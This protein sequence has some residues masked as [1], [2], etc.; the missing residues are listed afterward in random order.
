MATKMSQ[1]ELG[2]LDPETYA[3]GNPETFGLPLDAY[4]YLREEEP[5]CLHT[6]EDDLL[7]DEVYVVSRYADIEAVDRD[8]ETFSAEEVVNF[9]KF[10]PI[11]KAM[12]AP[13]M[14][15]TDGGRHRDQRRVLS[16]KFTPKAIRGLEER[17]R[18]YAIDVVEA[19]L[20]KEGPINFIDEIAHVMPM[21][22]LGDVLGVPE[23]DRPKFFHWVDQFAAPFD[24]RITPSFE[25]VGKAI[26]GLYEYAPE[27]NEL[28]LRE[29]GDDVMSEIARSGW[30]AEEVK[31]NVVLLASGAAEST[32]TSLGHGMHEFLR[33]PELMAWLR[34]QADDIPST[35]AQEMVRISTP[36]THLC[37][38]VK[39]ETE[40]NGVE[41]KPGDY[42]A[43]LFAAGNFDPDAFENPEEFDPQRSP[44]A[45]L[46]FGRGPHS[47][48]G[49]H[50]AALEIKILLEELLQRTSDIKQVGPI[51]YIK[52]AYSRGVYELP[53]QLT[54]A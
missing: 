2:V 34:T 21:Q 39:K 17:F 3:N 9:W 53:V 19:A 11:G 20:A 6:F 24:T 15:T 27:L 44:N 12:G 43:M 35:V 50:V 1:S 29:P 51:S 49:K 38:Y 48:L 33:N 36:F 32:R 45:H 30:S 26:M 13:A 7:L 10:A 54:R 5:V 31:G 47:C 14:L 4:K 25:D 18:T 41:L 42:V 52:D 16:P 40:L 46:S 28:R 8:A 22:A 37:R 23:E